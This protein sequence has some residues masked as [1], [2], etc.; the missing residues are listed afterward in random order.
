M[1][2]LGLAAESQYPPALTCRAT[3][4]KLE[5]ASG[6]AIM[7]SIS[8]SKQ[9]KV[10]SKSQGHCWYCGTETEWTYGP[11]WSQVSPERFCIDHV[12]PKPINMARNALANLAPCCW[13]CNASKSHRTLEGFRQSLARRRY[14]IPL[15]SQEHI[16]YLQMIGITLPQDFPCHPPIIFWFEQQGLTL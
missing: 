14:N 13:H 15:F 3:S 8:H 10:W 1:A 4:P 12:I 2:R 11:A 7:A 9:L 6:G 16:E 5:F